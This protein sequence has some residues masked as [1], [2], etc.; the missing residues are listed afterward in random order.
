M[1]KT[2]KDYY[3]ILG[4]SRNATKEEIKQAYRRLAKKYHPDMN[5]HNRKEAEEKFKE[6][7]EAYEVLMDDEKRKL[8]DLYG[9]EGLSQKFGPS[10]FTWEHFTHADEW[11]DI[12]GSS[13]DPF[14][15]LRRFFEEETIFDF[16]EPKTK[17]R[18]RKPVGGNIRVKMKLTLEDIAEGREKT[19]ELERYEKCPDCEGIGGKGKTTCS[20][21][22]GKGE[23]QQ[24]QRTAFSQIIKITTC[25]HCGGNGKVVKELCK[26]CGGSGRIKKKKIFKIKIPQEITDKNHLI[27]KG[28]GHYGEGGKGDIIIE[29][30]E[31]P[32]P[33]F[34][35]Q[36]TDLMVEVPIHYTT[37]LIGGEIEVPTL[38]GNKKIKIS[39]GV[40]DGQIIRIKGLGLKGQNISGDLLVKIKIFFPTRL[41]EEEKR[42][43]EELKKISLES[44]PKPYRPQE[45]K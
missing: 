18:K 1:E 24:I 4:V 30:E 6:I 22:K 12:F 11:R 15:F 25:P 20:V 43:L 8:Y 10:G 26:T 37:A 32:H 36:G 27:L 2:K 14:D 7:S 13:F 33:L 44:P 38:E 31:L 34:L 45:T 16:W 19:F 17:E 29:F 42:L 3:E 39:P 40:R 41:S 21:C 9:H 28:E 5:P 35:R 23:I